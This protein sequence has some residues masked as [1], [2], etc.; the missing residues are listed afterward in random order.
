MKSSIPIKKIQ[1][2][3]VDLKLES[4]KAGLSDADI[5]RLLGITRGY[6]ALTTS[7]GHI[8]SN[9]YPVVRLLISFLKACNMKSKREFG[10]NI[11]ESY[12]DYIKR[13]RSMVDALIQRFNEVRKRNIL[14]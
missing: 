11:G 8:S 10:R 4:D 7:K 3:I 6:Y 9:L 14:D 1:D 5:A 13:K 2:S 12:E